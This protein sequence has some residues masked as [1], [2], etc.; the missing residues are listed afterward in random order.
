MPPEFLRSGWYD[1]CQS[2]VWALG[3]ILVELLS[4]SMAFNRP[5][6]A[7]TRKPRIP[8]HL[9]EGISNKTNYR[10][11]NKRGEIRG[12]KGL[13]FTGTW[14]TGVTAYD[15]KEIEKRFTSLGTKFYMMI[16]RPYRL[17]SELKAL[18]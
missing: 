12:N 11:W 7:L 5:E 16:S 4:S 8:E 9:S 15:D 3:M 1:G 13:Y 6:Q 17:N 2:T 10:C 14:Q 18:Q